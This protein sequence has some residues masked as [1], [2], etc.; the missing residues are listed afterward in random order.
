LTKLIFST[1]LKRGCLGIP[2]VILSEA[3]NP[4]TVVGADLQVCPYF[5]LKNGKHEG[6][7]PLRKTILP[8]LLSKERHGGQASS[9]RF[10]LRWDMG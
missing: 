5:K 8:P 4:I 2:T 9:R 7:K 6:A 3:K 1:E 10:T